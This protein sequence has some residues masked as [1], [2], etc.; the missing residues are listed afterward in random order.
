MSFAD[1]QNEFS[2]LEICHSSIDDLDGDQS[3]ESWNL[4]TFSGSWS[5]QK[6]FLP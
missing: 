3:I 6:V 1:F 5:K 4:A 2:D